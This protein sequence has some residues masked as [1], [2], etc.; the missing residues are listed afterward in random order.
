[1]DVAKDYSRKEEPNLVL[2]Y[3]QCPI[4]SQKFNEAGVKFHYEE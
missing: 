2:K 4:C 1:M 3:G